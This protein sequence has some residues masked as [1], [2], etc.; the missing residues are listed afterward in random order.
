[1]AEIHPNDIGLAT[2][3]DVGDVEKLKTS[4]KNLVDALN[5]IYQN[6]TQGGNFGEQM[7]VDGENN[8]ILGENNI[9]YGSTNLIIGSD[10]IIVGDGVNIIAAGKSIYNEA[11]VSFDGYDAETRQ[12]GYYPHVDD[13]ALPIKTGDKVAIKVN[14]TWVN[15]DWTDWL[16][17]TSPLCV[18]EVEETDTVNRYIKISDIGVS[19]SPPDETHTVLDYQ[20]VSV[21][22][23]LVDAY[24]ELPGKSNISFGGKALGTT[25]F[26]AGSSTASRNNSFSANSASASANGS[27]AFC[28]GKARASFSF[29]ANY[30]EASGEKSAAFNDSEAYTSCALSAGT[31]SKVYGRPLKCIELN[32][33]ERTLT[34]D[35]RYSLTGIKKDSIIIVRSYNCMRKR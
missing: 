30:A 12:V 20:G 4:A 10:N 7:Y 33:S 5:E 16:D 19:M 15:E 18:A 2:F 1:M 8:I 23:P 17:I 29:A 28:G 35:S 6:G 22:I 3:A 24:K 13:A 32:W 14:Q 27:A 25:S 26:A 31:R 34:I 11:E 9:V 21:C